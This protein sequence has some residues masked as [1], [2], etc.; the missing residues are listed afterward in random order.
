LTDAAK[1]IQRI[2]AFVGI[3]LEGALSLLVTSVFSSVIGAISPTFTKQK[4]SVSSVRSLFALIVGKAT[5]F[6]LTQEEN[7][8]RQ[9]SRPDPETE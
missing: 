2:C 9:L 7:E 8:V 3:V 1:N 6:F 5:T 4:G